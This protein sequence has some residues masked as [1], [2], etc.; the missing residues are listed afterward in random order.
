MT[1]SW[2][3]FSLLCYES[4]DLSIK[5]YTCLQENIPTDST[6]AITVSRCACFLSVLLVLLCDPPRLVV[7]S[8]NL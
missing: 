6:Q 5:V 1:V 4:L 2:R 8:L 3:V 7:Q